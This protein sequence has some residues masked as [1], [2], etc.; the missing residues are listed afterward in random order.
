MTTLKILQFLPYLPCH[1][2]NGG[3]LRSLKLIEHLSIQHTIDL[4]CF[5]K[6]N[7]FPQIEPIRSLCRH[8]YPIPRQ[9]SP[10]LEQIRSMAFS[11]KPILV[12]FFTSQ[13]AQDTLSAIWNQDYDVVHVETCYIAQ[14]LP[15]KLINKHPLIIAESNIESDLARQLS[16]LNHNLLWRLIYLFDSFKLQ[17]WERRVWHSANRCIAVTEND[18]R[19]IAK[20]VGNHNV[21]LVENGVDHTIVPINHSL[22]KEKRILFV[23]NFRHRPNVDGIIYFI[24]SIWPDVIKKHPYAT[25]EIIGSEPP[26]EIMEFENS[27]GISVVGYIKNIRPHYENS[28]LSICPIRAGSGSR[29][30]I[31]DALAYGHP[32]VSTTVGYSGL[33]LVENKDILVANSPLEFAE[34]ICCLLESSELREYIGSNGRRTIIQQYNWLTSAEKLLESYKTTLSEAN[35]IGA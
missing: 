17:I 3:R 25:V 4:V 24:K 11:K 1:P 28:M 12:N 19:V 13:Y 15:T 16:A 35:I 30:K 8:I 22:V 33:R 6:P 20:S 2:L 23:G 5:V 32:V 9:A 14:N 31:L 18:L 7:E 21:S 10:S 26:V 34:S 29:I 27:P